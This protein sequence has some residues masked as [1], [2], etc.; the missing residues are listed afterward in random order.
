MAIV[1]TGGNDVQ[2]KTINNES[3]KGTGNIS[4]DG[5]PD[6][7]SATAGDVLTLDSN[8]DAIWQAPSGGNNPSCH[9]YTSFADFQ[10]D[11]TAH[12]NGCI[13]IRNKIVSNDHIL[14]VYAVEPYTTGNYTLDV[15]YIQTIYGGTQI[16]S[17]TINLTGSGGSSLVAHGSVAVLTSN[18]VTIADNQSFTLE[19]SRVEYWY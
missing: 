19:I 5:L 6:S 10:S 17:G 16:F 13:R 9:T 18:K 4:I 3:L 12:P 15:G 14:T 2:L 1:N 8:K 7:T 11:I